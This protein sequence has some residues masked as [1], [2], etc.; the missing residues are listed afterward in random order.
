MRARE[1]NSRR[2]AGSATRHLRRMRVVRQDRPRTIL[3]RSPYA[4]TKAAPPCKPAR[5]RHCRPMK[6][7]VSS[8]KRRRLQR[9]IRERI[10]WQLSSRHW[11]FV[12]ASNATN[13]RWDWKR[14]F[15]GHNLEVLRRDNPGTPGA[16]ICEPQSTI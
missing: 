11:A 4:V 13:P 1:V 5:H 15:P 6:R 10:R 12:S 9:V 14:N 3:R 7:R 8:R 16:G 2:Y